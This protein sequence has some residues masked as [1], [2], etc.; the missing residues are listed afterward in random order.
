MGCQIWRNTYVGKSKGTLSKAVKSGKLSVAEKSE[1]GSFKID[2]AELWRA[3]PMETETSSNEQSETYKETSSKRG[4]SN[5][6][7]ELLEKQSN[8]KDCTIEDLRRRLDDAEERAKKAEERLD[9]AHQDARDERD[10]FMLW[11]E[12]KPAEKVTPEQPAE[13]QQAPR[14]HWWSRKAK[15]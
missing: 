11:L 4:L 8:D 10:K 7:V 12:H 5:R 1:D 6:E 3:F 15:A 13:P 2:P 9:R 14:L